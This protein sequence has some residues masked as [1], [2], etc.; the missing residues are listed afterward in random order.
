MRLE[1]FWKQGRI[2]VPGAESDDAMNVQKNMQTS[3]VQQGG[4]SSSSSVQKNSMGIKPKF[5]AL[6]DQMRAKQAQM[7]GFMADDSQSA[8]QQGSCAN[9]Q[10]T[11]FNTSAYNPY[12]PHR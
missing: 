6:M 10:Q 9:R 7:Q 8:T 3:N 11:S 2:Q 4:N 12:V 1:K 5:Q